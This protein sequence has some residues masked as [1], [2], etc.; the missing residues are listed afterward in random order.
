MDKSEAA[1]MTASATGAA[2]IVSMIGEVTSALFGVPLPVVLAAVTGA[3]IARSYTPASNFFAAIM[4][5]IG[6]TFAGCSLAPL[7]TAIG[8]HYL[9]FKMPTNA[10]AGLA[11]VV[12]VG[13][14]IL[15]PILVE[16]GKEIVRS[17]LDKLKGAKP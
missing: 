9:S 11:F 5:T 15:F 2:A 3:F 14:P 17:H 4:A 1:A 13:L 12:S 10:L 8:D 7:A 16:K 6:W